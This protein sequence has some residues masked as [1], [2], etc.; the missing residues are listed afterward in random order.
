MYSLPLWKYIVFTNLNN[1]SQ[2]YAKIFLPVIV[3]EGFRL[4]SG[5]VQKY[6]EMESYLHFNAMIGIV[7]VVMA[8]LPPAL[9]SKILN[10]IKA[11]VIV[12]AYALFKV[13]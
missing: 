13:L 2:E 11:L 3:L 9:F 5:D 4:S 6:A 8:A 12:P 1:H 10:A 7:K